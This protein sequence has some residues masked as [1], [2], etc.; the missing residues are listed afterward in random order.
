MNTLQRGT[1]TLLKSAITEQSQP[2]PEGFD[3]SQLQGGFGGQMPNT[4]QMP[5]GFD[6]SQM[7]GGFDLS[8]MQG[9]FGGMFPGQSS[10]GAET[11]PSDRSDNSS[12]ENTN[13]PSRD[14]M[15]MPSGNFVPNMNSAGNAAS[16]I[17]NLV[18]LA[19]SVLILGMGLLIVK[20][21]KR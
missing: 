10:G 19:V 14:N 13:R 12:T 6:P 1:I 21:Y 4:D 16:G 3:F 17:T 2:L 5:Q 11:T 15:Q 18:L 20:L 8:Q 7:T 9:G